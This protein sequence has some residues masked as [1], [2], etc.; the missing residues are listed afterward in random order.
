MSR[1]PCWLRCRDSIR[2]CGMTHSYL[3][4]N[5]FTCSCVYMYICHSRCASREAACARQCH[6]WGA[7]CYDTCHAHLETRR[8]TRRLLSR[9]LEL[10]RPRDFVIL[11]AHLETRQ[12]TTYV[13]LGTQRVV[14]NT[15]ISRCGVSHAAFSLGCHNSFVR[16]TWVIHTCDMAYFFVYMYMWS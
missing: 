14:T 13:T 7:A 6:A 2:A 15:R 8:V 1:V 16:V 12:V 10:I 11:D 4:F 5:L 3:K 9:V